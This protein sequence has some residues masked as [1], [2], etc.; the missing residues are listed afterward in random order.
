MIKKYFESFNTKS[1]LYLTIAPKLNPNISIFLVLVS[2][3]VG[4]KDLT[5]REEWIDKTDF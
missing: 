5:F 3:L 4:R 1:G 2:F